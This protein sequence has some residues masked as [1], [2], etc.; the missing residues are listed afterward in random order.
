VSLQLIEKATKEFA[1]GR[2][3][4]RDR[5]QDLNDEIAKAKRN[6]MPALRRAIN[7]AAS[8][9][10]WLREAIERHKVLFER[11][12]TQI[13]HGIKVGYRK[14]KGEITWDD[15]GQVVKLIR[16][17]CPDQFD[18][19]VKTVETPSKE[20]LA[21]LPAELLKKLGVSVENDADEI[22]IKCTDSEIDKA[23]NALLKDAVAEEVES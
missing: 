19:L 9:H 22:F 1:D 13:F 3:D 6:A 5:L 14:M 4:L 8:R 15:D 16:K 12:R 10:S 20:A 2:R 18:V 7:A 11:P 21:L 23:V 17:H